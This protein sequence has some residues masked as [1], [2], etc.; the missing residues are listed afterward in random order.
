MD[1]QYAYVRF[2]RSVNMHSQ[3]DALKECGCRY[4]DRFSPL[5]PPKL[6]DIS[7]PPAGIYV[8]G[9]LPDPNKPSVAI[10]GSRICSQYG[11]LMAQEFGRGLGEQ[12]IQV[13]SGLAR[14]IDGIS[15]EACTDAGG[16]SFGVLG[17]GVNVVYPS[18][19]KKI[20]EKVLLKGGGLISE[21]SPDAPPIGSQF[22]A[23][24][25]IISALVDV[26]LVI[27]AKEK[28]GTGITVSKALEQGKDIYAVPGRITDICSQGCNKLISQG[29]GIAVSVDTILEIFGKKTSDKVECFSDKKS[30]ERLEKRVYEAM[31]FYPKNLD[32]ICSLVKIPSNEL[33]V[34]LFHLQMKGYIREIGRGYYSIVK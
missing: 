18:Q 33:S 16:T 14:G 8:K 3:S 20:Y 34:V 31:D 4:I 13:I 11:R 7:S 30:L 12:G 21:V 23:R 1:K 5:Y 10:V 6:Q 17:C 9:S 24:N 27:E 15:Q 19:N 22:A 2:T 28:S 32:E 29:A 25:R 26:V